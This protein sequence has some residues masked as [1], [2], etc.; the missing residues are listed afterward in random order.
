MTDNSHAVRVGPPRWLRRP[1]RWIVLAAVVACSAVFTAR[2]AVSASGHPASRHPV[3]VQECNGGAAI[4]SDAASGCYE[5]GGKYDPQLGPKYLP[6]GGMSGSLIAEVVKETRGYKRFGDLTESTLFTVTCPGS[7]L[8]G[9]C[10]WQDGTDGNP[11]PAEGSWKWPAEGG[12]VIGHDGQ[13]KHKEITLPVGTLIDRYG[14]PESGFF[15]SP[16]DTPYAERALPLSSLNTYE[17]CRNGEDD[18]DYSYH[19]YKVTQPLKVDSGKIRGW[20]GQPGGG[21]QYIT[22]VDTLDLKA[23][24][25]CKSK[26]TSTM[27]VASLVQE[28]KLMECSDLACRNT[29]AQAVGAR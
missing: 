23:V 17:H 21:E 26:G 14:C 15:L 3:A 5:I 11:P 20:F 16:Y 6:V 27:D 8:L 28:G 7:K 10:Y 25:V 29:R 9:A 22:C 1:R 4:G 19:L 12:Y 2:P 13:A 24:D 18:T